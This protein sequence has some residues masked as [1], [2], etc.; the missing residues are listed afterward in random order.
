VII[1]DEKDFKPDKL[2]DDITL[3]QVPL[4]NIAVEIG[5][6]ILRKY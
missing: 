6:K 4:S 2:R 5:N 3:L 1:Y